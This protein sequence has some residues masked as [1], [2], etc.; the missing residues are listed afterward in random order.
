MILLYNTTMNPK[1][2]N[3]AI[4][5]IPIEVSRVT[6]LLKNAGFSAYLVGGCVRDI[7]LNTPPK[8]WDI[9]TNATP[10][11]IQEIFP[12]SVYENTF[13][14]VGVKTRSDDNTVSII[15]ITPYRKESTYSDNRHPDTIEFSTTIHEDLERRDFTINALALDI[16]TGEIVD[17]YNGQKDIKDKVIRTVGNPDERFSEDALR[18]MRAIRF[19]AQLGF[20]IEKNTKISIQKNISLLK[21]ISIERIRDEF[22]KMIDSKD[23]ERALEVSRETGLLQEILPE[24]LDMVAIEQGGAHKYDVWTHLLKSLAYAEKKDYPL[25]VKLAALLHD[26]GKPKTRREGNKKAW[27]FYGHEVVGAR[28]TE[29][30][31]KRLKFSRET[32]EKVV[33]LVRWHMFFSDTEEISHTAIRRMIRNVGKDMIWDLMN[34]RVCDRMGMGRPKEDPYRLRK[35]HSMIEEVMSDPVSVGM[36]K[37]NGDILLKEFH[38]KPG[39]KI[40]HILHALLEE[41]IV[42]PEKNNLEYL[43]K[44]AQ[45]L[46]SLPEEELREKGKQ[47]KKTQEEKEQEKIKEIRKKHWVK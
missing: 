17:N 26:I 35:Y 40:G 4:S 9:T 41:V 31:L 23:P 37:I 33:K 43:S 2:L 29:K 14:T 32:T 24:L 6:A 42:D 39:P 8:D 44:R 30:I 3:K 1:T 38:M 25:H 13:G 28:M 46:D 20:D 16:E 18:L 19:S 36:L 21:N 47:G 15:E 10:Q 22:T 34:L 12:D 11:Q 27:T 45:E 7:F 5:E